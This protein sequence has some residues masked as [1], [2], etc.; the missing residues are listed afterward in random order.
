[1]TLLLTTAACA[2]AVSVLC[3]YAARRHGM[4]IE[5]LRPH[6]LLIAA[7]CIIAVLVSRDRGLPSIAILA[8]CAVC[9][10]SDLQTGYIFDAA[11]APAAAMFALLCIFGGNI[12]FYGAGAAVGGGIPLLLFIATR[13]SGIGFG[14]V[15]LGCCIGVL[16]A[17]AAMQVIE[18]AFI[19]GGAVALV[20]LARHGR[21]A[22][23]M[24]IPFAPFLFAG[25]VYNALM[26][27]GSL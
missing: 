24:E 21:G 15:K 26:S 9:A 25:V 4:R 8:V 1:M 6:V 2:L 20:L 22:R 16:G 14:D 13:G 5:L 10:V 19:A 18:A 7:V 27:R 12:E 3:A 17:A 11:I 23:R